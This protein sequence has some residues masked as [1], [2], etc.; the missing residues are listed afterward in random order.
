MERSRKPALWLTGIAM[1]ANLLSG[2]AQFRVPKIDPTGQAIFV[3]GQSTTIVSPFAGTAPVTTAP[4]IVTAPPVVTAPVVAAP[5]VV[6]AP[7]VAAPTVTPGSGFFPQPAWTTP[8]PLPPCDAV[9]AAPAAPVIGVPA[10]ALP[11]GVCPPALVCPPVAVLPQVAVPAA[12]AVPV[13]PVALVGQDSLVLTPSRIIAPVGGHVVLLAGLRN[14]TGQFTPGQPVEWILSNESVG[15]FVEVGNDGD[16]LLCHW[17]R[18]ASRKL[19]NNYA[20]G[21]TARADQVITRGNA[22]PTDDVWLMRG[23][24]WLSV[25]SP[26]E[27]VSLVTAVAPEAEGWDRRQQTAEIYWVNAQWSLPAPAHVRAGQPHALTTLITRTGASEPAQGWIARYDIM[28]GAPAAFT[29][30]G[31]QGIDVM[32]DATG[33][34]TAQIFPQA[35][36]AGATQVR[37][38]I[39][40]PGM[41]THEPSRLVVGEGVTTVTWSAPGLS[42]VMNGPSV[43]GVGAPLAYRIDI[44]NSGDMPASDVL[45]TYN[46]PPGI[47]IL[48]SNPSGSVFGQRLEWRL[49]ALPPGAT[50]SYVVTG[51]ADGPGDFNHCA[52]VQST[53][54]NLSAEH[55]VL[56]RVAQQTIALSMTGPEQAQVGEQVQYR[57]TVRNSGSTPLTDVLVRDQFDEGFEHAQSASPIERPLGN[58]A[59]GEE[60]QF[61]VTF[62]VSKPGRW[63]HTM[64]ATPSTGQTASAQGCVIATEPPAPQVVPGVTVRAWGPRDLQV[65]QTEAYFVEVLNSGQTPL[66]AIRLAV[67]TSASLRPL[68]A[69]ESDNRQQVGGQIVWTIARIEA[70]AAR[71]FQI[72]CQAVQADPQALLRA[73][74]TAREQ[75]Q[76]AAE[77]T[78]RLVAPAPAPQAQP[79]PAQKPQPQPQ[80]PTPGAAATPSESAGQLQVTIDDLTDSVRADQTTTY[81]IVVQ[82]A[83]TTSDRNVTLVVTLPENSRM[84]RLTGPTGIRRVSPD[85]RTLNLAPVLEI[86]AGETLPPYRI[87]VALQQA[88]RAVVRVEATSEN[89]SQPVVVEEDTTVLAP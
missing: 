77:A 50:Q 33:A 2:C 9:A 83:R 18:D 82:N 74:A 3:P 27:G 31:D 85:G 30:Q 51:Q 70:G 5:P 15:H 41:A 23:Q 65:G 37:V 24:S 25:S 68:Q 12:P 28:G 67:A 32:T 47:S 17:K 52:T 38:Q 60:K 73:E 61:A 19:S 88:G 26:T 89:Q 22:D 81:V 56:T 7:V 63:C 69:T 21:R 10:G 11:V 76:H 71:R 72:N 13:A 53:A 80:P 75:V 78:T 6:T 8:A 4:P 42:I 62:R 86:R 49:G 45:L 29:Q 39:I 84:V 14:P 58:L 57:V 44:T 66:T 55:C 59:P 36:S 43:A 46:A 1:M 79:A 64:T 16:Y 35:N 40:R 54:D 34:A 87:E 48:S 20:I